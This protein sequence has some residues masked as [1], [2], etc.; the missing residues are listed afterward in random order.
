MEKLL[1]QGGVSLKGEIRIAGAK[2]SALPILAATLLTH[3]TVKV[4]NLPHLYDIT[5][6]IE[7]MGCL[8]VEPIIDEKLNVE[9]NSSSIKTCTIIGQ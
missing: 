7:L 3:D 5:T 8:G 6:M 4:C 9:I 1:I 2:N